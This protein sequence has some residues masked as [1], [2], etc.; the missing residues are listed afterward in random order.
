MKE[1]LSAADVVAILNKIAVD[2]P[3]QAETL[4][5]LDAAI[6]DG[7]LG[8]TVTLG[9]GAMAEALPELAGTDLG[10]ILMK[11]G[12]AFNRKAASTFGALFATMMMRAARVAKGLD[13]LGLAQLA[14]MAVAAAD[15]VRE[16]GKSDVGNKTLLDALV[17]AAQ[18]LAAA[19]AGGAGLL[20]GIESA[21]AAAEAGMRATAAMKSQVGRASWFADRTEGQQDP[22]ATA[23]WMMFVSLRDYVAGL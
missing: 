22:G 23:I 12:M 11:S 1:T 16:R 13:E 17:P 3:A 15:G 7:D 4:R 20:A 21:T 9:L 19:A 6:G 8:I 14:E 2:V 10:N 5:V 18:A